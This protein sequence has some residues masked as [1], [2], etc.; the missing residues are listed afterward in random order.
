MSTTTRVETAEVVRA[1]SAARFGHVDEDGL[2]AAIAEQLRAV[3]DV[4]VQ[5][6]VRIGKGERIDVLIGRV[7]IEVK[8][9]GSA[10]AVRRQLAR[11]AGS[12][13]VDDLI[14]I[15]TR[16]AHRALHAIRLHDIPVT[17]VT[18]RWL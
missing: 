17:V 13:A 1:L 16:V 3:F 15:S 12:G 4:P 11:Y 6:E 5:R 14:L 10:G 2:Q 8:V 18:P 9:A 7:G